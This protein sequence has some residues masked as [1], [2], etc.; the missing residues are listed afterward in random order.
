MTLSCDGYKEKARRGYCNKN[1]KLYRNFKKG[2][3]LKMLLP[4]LTYQEEPSAFLCKI[5]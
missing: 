5:S 1:M 2:R 4:N 3:P